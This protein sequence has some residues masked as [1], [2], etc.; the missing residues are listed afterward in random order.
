[1]T[2]DR[3][4]V[5]DND[6]ERARLEKL[7]AGCTDADLERAVPGGW[8]VAGIFAH[9]AFWDERVR[10]LFERWQREGVAPAMENEA[11]VDWV[12]DSAKPMFLALPPRRAADL[13][14]GI[15]RA[16]DRVVAGLSDEMLARNEAAGTPLNVVRAAHRRQ[17]LDELEQV[18]GRAR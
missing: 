10:L 18:L 11:D 5:Q 2:A 9:L 3:R 8:T 7:V 14:V 4:Y 16:T 13:A 6:T 1:M 15:A 12:N 17:H